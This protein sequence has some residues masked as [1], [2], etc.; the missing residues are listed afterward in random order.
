MRRTRGLRID[1]LCKL[2]NKLDYQRFKHEVISHLKWYGIP[3]GW[4]LADVEK[5]YQAHHHKKEETR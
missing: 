2:A 1:R 5:F 3:V 4:T